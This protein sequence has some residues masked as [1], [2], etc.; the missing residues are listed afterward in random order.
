M[1]QILSTRNIKDNRKNVDD[2]KN[3]IKTYKFILF[4]SISIIF[5]F[6]FLI[7]FFSINKLSKK[8]I[9]N[10][11]ASNYE[12][13]KLYSNNNFDNFKNIYTYSEN[14]NNNNLSI[15]SENINYIIGNINI[16]SLD[17]NLPFFS[18]LDDSYL[19]ISPCRFFG[20]M[21]PNYGNLCIAGHN[22]D[23]NEFF[24]NLNRLKKDD[25]IIIYDNSEH[26]YS[27]KIYNIFEV[28]ENDLSPIYDFDINK[29]TLTLVTCNNLNKNRL[30]VKALMS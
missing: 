30:I 11:I 22:Y 29:H 20:E 5:V 3:K 1:N 10:R 17:L 27:Y 26:Q 2:K 13:L 7:A 18:Y 23:N 25:Q 28:K 19:S 4:V 16:P 15:N 12:T 8:Y 6:A 14:S 21:P 24:S 9:S